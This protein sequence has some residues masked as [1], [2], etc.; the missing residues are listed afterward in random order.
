MLCRALAKAWADTVRIP[1]VAE[2]GL[3]DARTWVA[4]LTLLGN[5]QA[6]YDKVSRSHPSWRAAGTLAL[7]LSA[8]DAMARGEEPTPPVEG[9]GELL[10]L[11][12]AS[13]DASEKSVWTSAVRGIILGYD[14]FMG[15]GYF[16]IGATHHLEREREAHRTYQLAAREYATG[17]S[18]GAVILAALARLAAAIT[19]PDLDT[20]ARDP[21]VRT[22]LTELANLDASVVAGLER[23]WESHLAERGAAV[24]RIPV[25]DRAQPSA[26]LP[27]PARPVRP[28]TPS[29][30]AAEEVQRGAELHKADQLGKDALA[31]LRN[32]PRALELAREADR[33]AAEHGRKPTVLA[34]LGDELV[35]RRAWAEAYTVLEERRRVQPADRKVVHLMAR[36]RFERGLYFAGRKLLTDLLGQPPGPEDVE[37]LTFLCTIAVGLGGDPELGRWKEELKRLDPLQEPLPDRLTTPRTPRTKIHVDRGADAD[38]RNRPARRGGFDPTGMSQDEFQANFLASFVEWLPEEQRAEATR[39]L[40]RDDPELTAEVGRLRDRSRAEEHFKAGERYFGTGRLDD[41][42]REYEAAIALDPDHGYAWHC[43][44]DVWYLRRKYDLA[45][46]YCEESVAIQ[47]SAQG[48]WLIGECLRNGGAGAHRARAYYQKALE[49]DPDYGAARKALAELDRTNPPRPFGRQGRLEGS[50]D[51]EGVLRAL[52]IISGPRKSGRAKGSSRPVSSGDPGSGHGGRLVS[53]AQDNDPDGF[54]QVAEDNDRTAAWIAAAS[55]DALFQAILQAMTIGYHYQIKDRDHTRW[56]LWAERQ[57]QLARALPR[58]LAPAPR[59]LGLGRDRLLADAYAVVAAVRTAEHRLPEAKACLLQARELLLAD[60]AAMRAAGIT[61][62]E[63]DRLFSQTSPHAS[64][65]HSL[66]TVCDRLGD[67]AACLTYTREARA[68]EAAHPTTGTQVD[69]LAAVSHIALERGMTDDGIGAIQEAVYLAEDENPRLVLPYTLIRALTMLGRT[70]HRLGFH[71][72]ALACFVRARELDRTGNSARLSANHFDIARVL[73]ARPDIGEALGGDARHH[74]EQAVIHASVP[75]EGST[76]TPLDWTASDGTRHRVIDTADATPA[77]LE[78]AG[79]LQES[80]EYDTAVH[81]LTMVTDAAVQLRAKAADPEQRIAVQNE[82]MAA[83]TQLTRLHFRRAAEGDPGSHAR[84]AWAAHESMRA[85]TFLDTLGEGDLPAPAG[86]PRELVAREATL[87]A[88][89]RR[90]RGLP[91]DRSPAFW[92]SYREIEGE[93]DDLWAQVLRRAPSAADYVQVRQGSPA[94]PADIARR[95]ATGAD[96]G[97]TVVLASLVLLDDHTLGVIA[98]RSDGTGPVLRSRA[99]DVRELG[100]FVR[101]NFGAADRVRLLATD[102]E[103]LFQAQLA[104]VRELLTSVCDPG[105]RLLVCPTGFLHHVP[106]GAVRTGGRGG[107]VLLERNPLGVLPS[108]SFLRGRDGSGHDRTGLRGPH[109]IQIFG[110]PTGDLPGARKE[111]QL[112]ARTPGSRLTLGSGATVDVVRRALTGSSVLHLAAHA[113]FDP[114]D[115]LGSG[116]LLA[117]GGVLTARDVIRLRAPDLSLVT[118]SACETGVSATDA[119]DELMGLPRALLFAGADSVVAGLWKVPDDATVTIMRAFYDGIGRQG[120][121]RIDALRAAALEAR[122][123]ERDP[124][125]FDRW[126]GFQLVGAWQ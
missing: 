79:L 102:A 95:L 86:V 90:L 51:A 14:L 12:L 47:P 126:A 87:L 18:Q 10:L 85:R 61:E 105:E 13:P 118:L 25:R 69:T 22:A 43:L 49:L 113:R 115:P 1:G 124:A 15:H 20:G 116:V 89:R 82:Q 29:P 109:G 52:G 55:P 62:S 21:G 97:R 88:R 92:D 54:A 78:L 117:G 66:A 106:L 70:R 111:A 81:L 83:F 67:R 57:L 65:L 40:T 23:A 73:R 98:L 112:L 31:S 108:G 94:D 91:G 110:D 35:R 37:T 45:Q 48:L 4:E 38:N 42:E 119:A 93:L 46:A 101:Q 104:P 7:L 36:C 63:Y 75:Q 125:R 99:A 72:S 107:E 50:L 26:Q 24:P 41:A 60:E 122:E 56:T 2:D 68:A 77:L 44:G 64:T 71:R 19:R 58:D 32:V 39:D 3:P 33:I 27:S 121:A 8:R 103:D 120:L 59:R 84:A 100:G 30:A 76:A 9:A 53:A 96:D 16:L 74:L 123:Q 28:S 17:R 11:V 114:D 5:P 80:G 34:A 6:V